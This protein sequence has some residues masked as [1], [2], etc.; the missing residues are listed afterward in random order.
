MKRWL[1]R[2]ALLPL[3]D[4]LLGHPMIS[5][6]KWLE[7]AQWWSRERLESERNRLLSEVVAT[8]YREVHLYRELFDQAGVNPSQ[9]TCPADLQRLPVVT[10]TMLRDAYPHRA[11]RKVR[12][13]TYEA[14]TSGSTGSNFRVREDHETAGWYRASFL[15]A[16]EWAGWQLGEPHVQVGMTIHRNLE[17]RL[18]DALM[19]CYYVPGYDLSDAALDR[20]LNLMS[21]KRIRHLW[22]YPGSL[23]CLARRAQEVGSS[24]S[25]ASI[26]TWGD[27]LHPHYRT[28]MEQAFGARVLDTYGCGE[29]MQIAAQCGHDS[30]YHVH[31]LDV[32]VEFLDDEGRPVPDGQPGHIV[33]TRLH[34]GPM[35]FI[36]YAVGDIG[37]SAGD[38]HCDCGRVFKLLEGI[39]GRSADYVLTLSGNR[40]IVHFF[41]GILEHFTE[42]D[43]FQ[44][45]Q[46]RVGAIQLRIVPGPG[47]N[48]GVQQKIC[49]ALTEKGADLEIEVEVVKEIPLTSGG[50]R[51]F[52]VRTVQ[53]QL[54]SAAGIAESSVP[55]R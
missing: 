25:L 5:R 26:V 42:V 37:R 41:T 13:R 18:K 30:H 22:G 24:T 54:P 32:V 31:E 46:E 27:Q 28:K 15:L 14:S 19:G 49:Q 38:R 39:Q 10:K 7:Q 8:S 52:V 9:I 1:L 11:C 43:S 53:S 44:V 17:R 16:L 2:N 36:R 6:L 34:A 4:R 33:L 12:G 29:G 55:L 3:G 50:K 47:F 20:C 40:L 45:I 48:E 21:G 35:P 23:F 51:R